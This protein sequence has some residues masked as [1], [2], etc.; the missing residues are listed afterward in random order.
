MS[1]Y[2]GLDVSKEETTF[3]VMDRDGTLLARGKVSTDPKALFGTLKEHCL[4]PER[5][6]LETGTL[7]GWLAREL[8]KL[9]IVVDVIDARHAN[10][11]MKLQH[12]KTDAND[13]ELLA[14]IARTGFCRSVAVKSETAQHD[15]ARGL[16][17]RTSQASVTVN[18]TGAALHVAKGLVQVESR[19]TRQVALVRPGQTAAVS[20]KRG[21]RIKLT[22]GKPKAKKG[23]AIRSGNGKPEASNGNG[24]AN[25]GKSPAI[26]KAGKGVIKTAIGAGGIDVFKATNGLVKNHG[27]A[28][29]QGRGN[30]NSGNANV[31]AKGYNGNVN[32]PSSVKKALKSVTKSTNA[33]KASAGNG[34]GKG[35]GKKK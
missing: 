27:P 34:K 26:R 2:V 21:T 16:G 31:A 6:V 29:G 35:K 19:L 28:V 18:D 23:A 4:C 32:L 30:L 13:A 7:S 11:V 8:G 25:G 22:G 33:A 14:D 20:S 3:C 5:I 9:G 15:R 17:G 1:E 12:N 24:K 10:A